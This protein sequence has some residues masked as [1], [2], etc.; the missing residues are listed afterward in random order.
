MPKHLELHEITKRKL[1][2]C[3]RSRHEDDPYW[4][5]RRK[6]VLETRNQ[7]TDMAEFICN[8]PPNV[9]LSCSPPLSRGRKY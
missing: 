7:A 3:Q 6:R 9:R 1:R 5:G 2:F 8:L 4:N